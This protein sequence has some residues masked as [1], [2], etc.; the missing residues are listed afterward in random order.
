MKKEGQKCSSRKSQFRVFHINQFPTDR[1]FVYLDNNFHQKLFARIKCYKFKKFNKLFFS[2]KL[3]WSTFKQWK[4]RKNFIPL[5]FIIKLSER[6]PEFF[7]QEFEKNIIAYKGPSTSNVIKKPNLPL[8]E[9]SRLFKIVSHLLGDGSVGGGFGSNLP[10][11]KNHSEYRNFNSKLLNIFQKDLSVFGIVP[12][13]KNYKRGTLM[14]SNVIGYILKHFYNIKFDTY[15]SRVPRILFDLPREL[16]A[17]FLRAFG[18]DEGHVYDSSIDYYSNNKKLLKDILILMNKVFPEIR[19]SGI[20][21]NAKAG[22]NV[23]YSFTVY[24]CSQ[25]AYLNLIGFDHKQ[26][27]EDLIFNLNRKRKKR[28]KISEQEILGLLKNNNLT[29]K[30]ISRLLWIRHSSV[31]HRL[32]KLKKL[33]KVEILRKRHWANIWKLSRI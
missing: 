27:R 18:D 20:K 15:N 24:N 25:E 13:T 11:G 22:K 1:I 16:V 6:F 4:R 10:K 33:G 28:N 8:V 2:N 5:W 19:T 23:K 26:K 3:N 31:L 29:A 12:T 32:N 7:I 17:S 30:Q 21:L 14:I 9:D